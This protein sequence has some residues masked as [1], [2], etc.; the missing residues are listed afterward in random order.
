MV[1]PSHRV[2]GHHCIHLVS[3]AATS[4]CAAL[5]QPLVA[6]C[7]LLAATRAVRQPWPVPFETG[8]PRHPCKSR[9]C[10]WTFALHSRLRC[11]SSEDSSPREGPAWAGKARRGKLIHPAGT[12]RPAAVAI[13]TLKESAN[14]HTGHL[15]AAHPCIAFSV[16][17]WGTAGTRACRWRCR[18]CR[19]AG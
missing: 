18:C 5:T 9:K 12:N 4:G 6:S 15:S 10:M 1:L 13:T 8:L 17:A 14:R 2:P 3:S 19:A 16:I 7:L 11:S